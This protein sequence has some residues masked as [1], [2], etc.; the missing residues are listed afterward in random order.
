MSQVPRAMR[1]SRHP[2]LWLLFTAALWGGSYAACKDAMGS[3]SPLLLVCARFAMAAVV[4]SVLAPGG[5]R[6]LSRRD[7][8]GGCALGVILCG[9]MFLQNAA[10][11]LTSTSKA[12]FLIGLT[13]I[14]A[15]F[16][17]FLR[18]RAKVGRW[19]GFG[20][21]L[22]L[23]GLYGL[24]NPAGGDFNMGDGLMVLGAVLLSV[25]LIAVDHFASSNAV[26]LTIVQFASAGILSGIGALTLETV[27]LEGTATL[28]V[29]L[30]YLVVFAT[31]VAFFLQLRYQPE[32]TPTRAA[33]VLCAEP[34]VAA[35]VGVAWMD[36]PVTAGVVIGGTLILAG[37]LVSERH[38][39]DLGTAAVPDPLH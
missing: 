15:P 20:A 10:V 22:A 2:E 35:A 19:Q 37:I 27:R 24:C 21:V 32:T 14:I 29:S 1:R 25:H 36:E 6:R 31:L 17:Q 33:V 3:I 34:V 4:L 5:L 9:S 12:G 30:V 7:L 16:L 39:S 13:V 23:V 18:G 8:L 26:G 38:A 28:A 11:A